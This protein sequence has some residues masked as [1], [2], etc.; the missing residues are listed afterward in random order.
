PAVRGAVAYLERLRATR[1]TAEYAT[2]PELRARYGLLPESASHEGYLAHPVH[3]YW[4]DFWALQ[5]YRDAAVMAATLGDVAEAERIGAIRDAFETAL[6]ASIERTIVERAIPYVPGSVEWADFDPTATS[7]AVS[8]LGLGDR[9][10]AAALAYTYDEYV[11]GFRRRR[12][13]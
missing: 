1:L 5:G 11:R 8:L 6:Y 10:P 4:D 12:R 13:G 2:K 9:L 7:N 3:A